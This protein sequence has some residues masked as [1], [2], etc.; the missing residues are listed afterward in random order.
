MRFDNWKTWW[1]RTAASTARLPG[2]SVEYSIGS[3]ASVDDVAAIE[4]RIG[5][6]FPHTLVNFWIGCSS[7]VKLRWCFD[8][9]I[10][11]DDVDGTLLWGNVDFDLDHFVR[12]WNR[13]EAWRDSY[14]NW[15]NYA[16]N[17]PKLTFAD[18]FPII[19]V[20]SGDLIVMATKSPDAGRIYYQ[21]R[22][23]SR[24]D[25]CPLGRSF[26]DFMERWCSLGCVGPD[27]DM[28]LPFYDFDRG[29]LDVNG[30]RARLWRE[31]LGIAAE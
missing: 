18:L 25:W 10:Q 9:P 12:L 23:S 20:E 6:Q 31:H 28:L 1:S 26:E 19:D 13:W 22:C 5:V 17:Y 29:E 4:T 14:D 30:E 24:L 21:S 27:D 16:C 3:P 15:Q 7:A 11:F 2:C 8:E